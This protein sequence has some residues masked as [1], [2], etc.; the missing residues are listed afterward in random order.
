[1]DP[2]GKV[3]VV[4]GGNSGLGEGGARRLLA[5]GA[6]VVSLD[7]GGEAPA[8]ADFVHCDVS[9]EA[10]VRQAIETV[11]Q[12]HGRIDILLNNA[13]IGGIGP[14]ADADG[15]GDLAGFR[16]VLGVN[17]IGAAHAAAVVHSQG[18]GLSRAATAG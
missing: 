16:R 5:A 3:A 15:P 17:L 14:I 2:A 9:D 1:M 13:G 8:E 12:R 7:V 18:V 11:I 6:R 4:T 10:A